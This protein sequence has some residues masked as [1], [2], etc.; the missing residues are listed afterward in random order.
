MGR[1][2]FANV[3]RWVSCEKIGES[4][5]VHVLRRIGGGEGNGVCSR[6]SLEMGYKEDTASSG[7]RINEVGRASP[8][9]ALEGN[10]PLLLPV[11][12]SHGYLLPSSLRHAFLG[13]LRSTCDEDMVILLE[14]VS[15]VSS[16][17]ISIPLERT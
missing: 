2:N 3:G 16:R 7:I 4:R 17:P 12:S 14:D 15:G 5:E 13:L 9:G 10:S 6:A 1:A 8:R 11:F